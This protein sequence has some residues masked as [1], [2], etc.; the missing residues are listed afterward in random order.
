[1]RDY[2]ARAKALVMK[3]EQNDVGTTKRK[4]TVVF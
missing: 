4:L 1:M 3:L 2:I